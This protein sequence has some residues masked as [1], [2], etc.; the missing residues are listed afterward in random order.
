MDIEKQEVYGF[1]G[2]ATSHGPGMYLN[3]PKITVQSSDLS[4]KEP[5]H[6]QIRNMKG[7]TVEITRKVSESKGKFKVY[8]PKK[9]KQEL[10]L[11][12]NEL[13]DVFFR[14]D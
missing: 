5:V 13:V 6:L 10:C 7:E 8:L 4:D 9:V 2:K 3:I 14:K 11:D 1:T 12:H